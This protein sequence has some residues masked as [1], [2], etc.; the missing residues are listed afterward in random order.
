MMRE[1]VQILSNPDLAT[2][3]SIDYTTVPAGLC[4]KGKMWTGQA[5]TF[6]ERCPKCGRNG[7]V[8]ATQND[9][10]IMVHR[11][12]VTGDMLE[13][14]DYCELMIPTPLPPPHDRHIENY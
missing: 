1:N 8:S 10:R 11:G 6:T 3:Q 14:I 4:I 12:R 5:T 7:V 2:A 9:K 13:G